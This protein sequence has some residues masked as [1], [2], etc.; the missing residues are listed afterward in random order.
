MRLYLVRHSE[1]LPENIDPEKHL[2][3]AGIAKVEAMVKLLR[4]L[5]LQVEEIMH[6]G[7][8]RA[9][10]TAEILSGAFHSNRGVNAKDR[11]N[12][13]DEVRVIADE[14]LAGGEDIM[15]VGHLPFMNRLASYLLTG[16][17]EAEYF[18]FDNASILCVSS[19][20]KNQFKVEWFLKPEIIPP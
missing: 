20:N 7:K 19:E 13:N 17:E 1:A 12:P 5:H 15:I 10:Q 3:S 14:L 18:R 8:A 2:S 16:S 6:S 9:Q 11:L 4:G